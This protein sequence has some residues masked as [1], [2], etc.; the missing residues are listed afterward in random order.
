M[1]TWLLKR[2]AFRGSRVAGCGGQR[3]SRGPYAYGNEWQRTANDCGAYDE[4]RTFN[5]GAAWLTIAS[6]DN[7]NRASCRAM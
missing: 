5:I 2:D 4:V 7:K 6:H 1:K 3:N